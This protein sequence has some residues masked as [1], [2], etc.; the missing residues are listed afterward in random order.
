MPMLSTCW[1]PGNRIRTSVRRVP[2]LRPGFQHG[3][4]VGTSGHCVFRIIRV[5]TGF[6]IAPGCGN[7][8]GLLA[9]ALLVF[10]VISVNTVHVAE[11]SVPIQYHQGSDPW[12]QATVSQP[13]ARIRPILN[14]SLFVLTFQYS[15]HSLIQP[16]DIT[17]RCIA[18]HF[19]ETLKFDSKKNDIGFFCKRTKPLCIKTYHLLCLW[20]MITIV[21]WSD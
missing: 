16:T 10:P 5:N 8:Y 2:L 20:R 21:S 1:L 18:H 6:Y 14:R 17:P 19:P 7:D 11:Q 15:L 9:A 13:F 3:V 4:R 12:Q